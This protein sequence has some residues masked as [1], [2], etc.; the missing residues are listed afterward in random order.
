MKKQALTALALM[1]ASG[2]SAQTFSLDDLPTAPLTSAFYPGLFSA[3]DPFG[4]GLPPVG[5]GR[6]GP[7]P[8]LITAS[9]IAYVDGDLLTVDPAL[10]GEPILDIITPLG[11]YL[12]AVSQDHE[13]FHAEVSPEMNIRFSVDRATT[14]LPG[15]PLASEFGFNQQPGDIYISE[16]LFPN[17]GIYVGT[18]GAGPFGGVLPTAAAVPG[19]H[20]LEI[21]ESKL[22][23]TAGLGAGTFIP[24]GVPAPPIGRGTHDNVDAY[25]VLPNMTMD[26]DGD[27]ICDID[28]FLSINPGDAAAFGVGAADIFALPKGAPGV[29]PPPYAPAPM[30]GLDMLGTPPN[31]ELQGQRDDIDGLVVWDFGELHPNGDNRAEPNRDYAI[32]SLSERSASLRAL[33]AAGFPVDGS[34]IFFTDFTGSFAIYLFGSQVGIADFSFGD[35]QFSNLDALEICAEVT[36]PCDPCVLADVNMDG[37]VT[38]TDFTAWITAFNN[39]APEC[40]QNCDGVCSPTDFTAWVTNYNACTP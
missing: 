31:P 17:P 28:S 1:I 4:L 6:I 40:D 25:N 19:M 15:S 16:R 26:L 36:Q 38:A 22:F 18:L 39:N 37:A 21:D 14:G 12:D 23:L 35:Q 20:M 10:P 13:I 29:I 30:M 11:S 2:A 24:A 9:G 33:R 32:F 5:A 7:S 3:E 34:T 27:A 8:T